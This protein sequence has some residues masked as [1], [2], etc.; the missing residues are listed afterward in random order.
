MAAGNQSFE[1]VGS[2]FLSCAQ[3]CWCDYHNNLVDS[4]GG[5]NAM[6][7]TNKSDLVCVC[8]QAF[9]AMTN[10]TTDT[11]LGNCATQKCDDGI[12]IEKQMD[13]VFDDYEDLCKQLID[14]SF[15][16]ATNSQ[17][18]Q[19][20]AERWTQCIIWGLMLL[21]YVALATEPLETPRYVMSL[22]GGFSC[23]VTIVIT[24]VELYTGPYAEP[25]ENDVS[26]LL[27][28]Q[29]AL[30]IMTI[31]TSF[32]IPRH[33]QTSR[34]GRLIDGES[35]SSILGHLSFSWA[36]P[37]VAKLGNN[38]D[39]SLE[40]LPEL[41]ETVR[42]RTLQDAFDQAEGHMK[43][44]N[45][46][47]WRALL[48][49]YRR[50]IIYQ[51]VFSLPLALLAFAPHVALGQMLRL[52]E[53]RTERQ[54]HDRLLVGWAVLLGFGIWTSSWLEN[55]LLWIAHSRV[56]IPM[57]QQLSMVLFD[58]ATKLT[59]SSNVNAK[60]GGCLEAQNVINLAAID[61][62]RIA[63]IAGFLYSCILQ[64][65]KVIVACMLLSQLLGW[66]SLSVG[67]M[68]LVLI[69]PMHW[70]CLKRMSTAEGILASRRDA[71]MSVVAEVLH[72]I[73]YIKF[74]A[75][76]SKWEAGINALRDDELQAQSAVFHRQ[77]ASLIL[78]LLGP[79]LVSA[80]SLGM[81]VRL[82]GRL[83][84]STAFPALSIFGY[85]QFTLG[86]VPELLSGVIAAFVSLKRMVEF[87]R[88]REP[89]QHV[90]HSSGIGIYADAM[91]YDSTA[92]LKQE[93]VLREV[94]LS[95]PHQGLSLICG[96]TGV[97]KSLLLAAI[98]GECKIG[99]GT[100]RRPRPP[101]FQDVYT[102]LAPGT[103]WI[104]D[105]MIA[106]V[107][108]TPWIEAG[109]VRSNI[110]FG[111]PLDSRRYQKV[112][113]ACALVHDLNEFEGH[114]LADI[115]PSGVNLSGGQKA[116][117]SL[118]RALYS[119]AGV[120]LLDDVLSAV[121]V[122]TA[123]HLL[124]HALTGE[125]AQG[126]TR[127]LITHNIE[128]SLGKAD[129]LVQLETGRVKY[130][131]NIQD[132]QASGYLAP[133]QRN[134]NKSLS[135]K[136][137]EHTIRDG[138]APSPPEEIVLN[139][140]N[141]EQHNSPIV[142]ETHKN[143]IPD[144]SQRQ[145]AIQWP[146]FRRYIQYSG[147]WPRGPENDAETWYYFRIYL[148]LAGFVCLLGA[149]RS[150]LAITVSLRAST[151][152]F[153][154]LL[155]AVLRTRM[156]WVDTVPVGR[157]INRFTADLYVLDSRLGLDLT[158]LFNSGMDCIGV[159]MGAVLVQPILLFLGAL[160]IYGTFWYTRRYLMAAREVKHL[161]CLAR[162]PIY[163]HFGSS[164]EGIVTIRAFQRTQHYVTRMQESID[165]H[166]QA[167][168]HLG[169]FNQWF[170]FR[171][172]SL[173]ALFSLVTALT[174]IS[175]KDITGSVAGFA[176]VFTNHLCFALVSL[177][178]AYATLEMDF[179]SVDRI[180]E[181]SD[182]PIEGV[183]GQNPPPAWPR[184]GKLIV[185]NLTARYNSGH[186]PVLQK[187]TFEAGPGE[188]IAI[189]GRTGAGKSSLA[190]SL[191]RFLEASEGEIWIDGV[192]ISTIGLTHL[193]R[194][195]AIIPQ[196]PVLFSGTVRSNLDPFGEHSNDTLLQALDQVHW[197]R[198]TGEMPTDILNASVSKEG[199]NCSH[200][201]RQLL[202]LARAMLTRPTILILDEA[203]S[204]VDRGTDDLVQESIRVNCRET[205]LLVIAHRIRTIADFD[206]VLVLENGE[207]VEFGSPATLLARDGLFKQM[208][209]A[210]PNHEELEGIIGK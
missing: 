184:G 172:N 204:A 10:T 16:R 67:L 165:K 37:L 46:S 79:V 197:N 88:L 131:G 119:R 22:K 192:E 196:N 182:L 23:G 113:N 144:E 13:R 60:T 73:R 89:E 21:Q 124:A 56:A 25:P 107:A 39:I 141:D 191:F 179:N 114:D 95:F 176:L 35:S 31:L 43:P 129:Y 62:P 130:A 150:Y 84:P 167:V 75:L 139:V 77:I 69:F 83:T 54:A 51:I 152:L 202:C 44:P 6:S 116:R 85:L 193:R 9:L 53:S 206:R 159:I 148:V 156:Q 36:T 59:L 40:C 123:K 174:V 180:L 78:H 208:V 58:K 161:E 17:N 33:Q 194:R 26:I 15:V 18:V 162:S 99:S 68:C 143:F 128:V 155:H 55:W 29:I 127:I 41:N 187:V 91:D 90:S 154:R 207:A 203:T 71:K 98:L 32:S 117:I 106:Y 111:L 49:L 142:T 133:F 186:L 189:V 104:A 183:T 115:G 112:L 171:I 210:D 52:L 105:S 121:D 126:R 173:G 160:L 92:S 198:I 11:H 200:G 12:D 147:G 45:R 199:S 3:P 151:V 201:Q 136:T 97:G 146:L 132:L 80:V 1:S 188:R 82:Y 74:A 93:G 135:F 57:T 2:G 108:Q 178:R 48:F 66:K 103:P 7:S 70:A 76:E 209:M 28:S 24:T 181:Y 47:L 38:I 137:E 27:Y 65:L 134:E 81:Y 86:I 50:H 61:V 94:S 34:R 177:S 110:L 169:L 122:H 4:D 20:P 42:A 175:R 170:T 72:G 120:L 157:I 109:T 118:A 100:V 125:L 64:P 149:L 195:L 158:T 14:V 153:R 102:P 140:T 205:T 101:F 163:Q 5:E 145:G 164:M 30:A 166:A 168:W 96:P 8:T 19:F 63:T 87:L 138:S 185:N 190:L